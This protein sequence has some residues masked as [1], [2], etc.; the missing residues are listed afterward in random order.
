MLG[1]AAERHS[2]H[3]AAE[4]HKQGMMVLI[5]LQ[6]QNPPVLLT[7]NVAPEHKQRQ[8]VKQRNGRIHPSSEAR[9]TWT[10]CRRRYPPA[11][12]IQSCHLDGCW[13]KPSR[14]AHRLS[15]GT[16]PSGPWKV[17]Q[18]HPPQSGST[19]TY[20]EDRRWNLFSAEGIQTQFFFTLMSLWFWARVWGGEPFIPWPWPYPEWGSGFGLLL[21]TEIPLRPTFRWTQSSISAVTRWYFKLKTHFWYNCFKNKQIL[22]TGMVHEHVSS[23]CY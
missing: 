15:P 3:T 14:P 23:C 4:R 6:A 17:R 12:W 5:E 19:W 18:R 7:L 21:I 2:D 10:G 8:S 13:P 20:E 22:F 16:S 11:V 1:A 9:L